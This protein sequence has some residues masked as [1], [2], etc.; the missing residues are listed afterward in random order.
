MPDILRPDMKSIVWLAIG[1]LVLPHI[2]N[3]IRR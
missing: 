2:Q 3:M 1:F